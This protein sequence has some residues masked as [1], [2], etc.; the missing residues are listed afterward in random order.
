MEETCIKLN[1]ILVLMS[2]NVGIAHGFLKRSALIQQSSIV[3]VVIY[4]YYVQ[5]STMNLVFLL[6]TK[7]YKEKTKVINITNPRGR[8]KQVVGLR[9]GGCDLCHTYLRKI[10]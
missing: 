3:Y 2:D 9:F 4:E 5:Y 7:K 6:C 10:Q 8:W 1:I